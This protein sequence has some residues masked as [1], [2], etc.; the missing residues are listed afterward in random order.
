MICE[1]E[2][3]DFLLDVIPAGGI[4]DKVKFSQNQKLLWADSQRMKAQLG[5]PEKQAREESE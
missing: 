5:Q 1:N 4:P 3:F 2:T